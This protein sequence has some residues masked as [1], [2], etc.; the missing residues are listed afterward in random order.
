ILARLNRKHL[1]PQEYAAFFDA[2]Q[3]AEDGTPLP[4]PNPVDDYSEKDMDILPVSDPHV[5][6]KM[7][8]LAKAQLIREVA[9]D[10]PTVNPFEATRRIFEAADIEDIDGLM[11]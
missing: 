2:P 9:Q 3:Q 1:D 4:P 5:A 11:V 10:N 7:Q 6:S 8:Q